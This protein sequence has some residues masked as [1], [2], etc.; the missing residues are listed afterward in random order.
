M[1]SV[2]VEEKLNK[3]E[4]L[5]YIKEEIIPA[6]DYYIEGTD[7]R[8]FPN[9]YT[10][11]NRNK[12]HESYSTYYI[13]IYLSNYHYTTEIYIKYFPEEI[14]DN[15]VELKIGKSPNDCNMTK[16]VEYNPGSIVRLIHNLLFKENGNEL[17]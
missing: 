5:K 3:E 6:I 12:E 7:F 16:E 2:I 9:V 11:Y 10:Y 1:I 14:K 4:N 8:V 17:L 15:K 13:E